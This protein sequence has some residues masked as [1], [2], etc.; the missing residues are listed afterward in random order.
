MGTKNEEFK[1]AWSKIVVKSWQDPDFKKKLM[2]NPEAVLKEFGIDVPAGVDL[3]VSE[4]TEKSFNLTL[5]SKPSGNLSD[6]ELESLAGGQENLF[7]L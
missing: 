3:K 4:N 1:N 6:K 2:E 5:P 7:N